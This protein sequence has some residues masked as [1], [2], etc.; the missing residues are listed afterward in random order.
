MTLK[1]DE[2]IAQAMGKTYKGLNKE[3]KEQLLATIHAAL[4]P[5]VRAAHPEKLEALHA[6]FAEHLTEPERHFVAD[7]VV[8]GPATAGSDSTPAAATPNAGGSNG[9]Q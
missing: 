8:D 3:R 5:S 4:N 2:A 6:H 7:I 1:S 9:A